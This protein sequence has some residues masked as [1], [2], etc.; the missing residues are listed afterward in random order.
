M[1]P[2]VKVI[3]LASFREI[4]GKKEIFKEISPNSTLRDVLDEL[5]KKYGKDFKQIINPEK[6]VISPEFIV[7]INGQIARNPNTKLN[8]DDILVITIPVGGG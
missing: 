2:Q 1:G 7:S 8:N 4:V 5:A 3:L 6:G